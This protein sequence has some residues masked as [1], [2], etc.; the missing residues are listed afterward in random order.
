MLAIVALLIETV[1]KDKTPIVVIPAAIRVTFRTLVHF[2][3]AS[4]HPIQEKDFEQEF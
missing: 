1:G 2:Y 3:H 4:F